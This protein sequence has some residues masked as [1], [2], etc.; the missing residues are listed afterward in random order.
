MATARTP[1]S[2]KSVPLT[3]TW[4]KVMLEIKTLE[5]TFVQQK[6]R[7]IFDP[8]TKAAVVVDPGGS[9]DELMTTI[10]ELG[11]AV[12][13][14]LI[15]HAHI[16]HCGA[17]AALAQALSVPVYGPHQDDAKAIEA[18][19]LQ[20]ECLNIPWSGEFQTQFVREGQVLELLPGHPISVQHT[21]GHSRGSVC[22]YCPDQKLMLVGDLLVHG[23]IW[24]RKQPG[25]DR[26]Q[27]MASLTR[28]KTL[29][30]DT[31]LLFGHGPDSTL[32]EEK[33]QNSY[34]AQA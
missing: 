6:C 12:T 31:K 5:V 22:Y 9:A 13:G 34:L 19:E 23:G 15:T 25:M 24:T 26:A 21:P 11:L 16:D 2:G 10:K 18:L 3:H 7:L 1:R 4:P 30:D 20:G 17:V 29:P 8:E 27:L 14:I 32:G 33:E 28:L